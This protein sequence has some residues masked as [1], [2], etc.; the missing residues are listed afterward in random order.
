M[1]FSI[2]PS[3]KRFKITYLAIHYPN[4]SNYDNSSESRLGNSWEIIILKDNIKGNVHFLYLV[5]NFI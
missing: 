4:N 3:E 5:M 2:N 1:L